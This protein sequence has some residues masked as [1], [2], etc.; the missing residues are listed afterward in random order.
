MPKNN[1]MH[2]EISTENI[3]DPRKTYVADL[4]L[5]TSAFEIEDAIERSRGYLAKVAMMPLSISEC[6]DVPLLCDLRLD[7]PTLYELN[8][9]AKQIAEFDDC[10]FAAYKAFL[11]LVVGDDYEDKIISIK[12]L[13]NLTY[14]VDDYMVAS[15]IFN[16]KDLGE[17]LLDNGLVNGIEDLP[18]E[19][20]D[21]LDP[22][23]VGEA[24]R[25]AENGIYADGFYISREGFKLKEIYD[26]ETLPD[27]VAD[28]YLFRLCISN[29]SL[30]N[31]WIDVPFTA[32]TEKLLDSAQGTAFF[33]NDFK[34]TIPQIV[35][36]FDDLKRNTIKIE[37]LK[38]INK[39]AERFLSA[40]MMQQIKFKA[41]LCYEGI[42]TLQ[43]MQ[44]IEA[45]LNTADSYNL[46][47][48]NIYPSD[49]AYDY[50]KKFLNPNF[51]EEY[52]PLI[53]TIRLG[54]RLA[55]EYDGKYTPYGI[56]LKNNFDLNQE[57]TNTHEFELIEICGRHV[58]FTEDR[59]SAD[60]IPENLFRYEFRSGDEYTYAT[61]EEKVRVDFSGT[62]LSKEPFD[63][64]NDGYI[65]ITTLGD[66]Y[67]DFLDVSMSVDDFIHSD[68]DEDEGEEI[69]G[70][71][72][73]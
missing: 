28:N 23:K 17:L 1:V 51:P 45:V 71:M 26:G 56:L 16:D 18:D 6:K 66:G 54:E 38:R 50:L 19:I 40:D 10:Q 9:L 39:F 59:L 11:P 29:A 24:H 52:L 47:P 4:H 73:L 36:C 21:M 13:I 69:V 27:N 42:L 65:D 48:L 60:E 30:N 72:Q 49:F 55:S 5:P 22:D 58:L 43:G 57:A 14:C 67:P 44:R 41:A 35:N 53:G 31:R 8:Y 37:E 33:L 32:D 25:I 34:S 64:G 3:D 7:S 61:L 63:L 12:D 70:G 46:K 2:I 62:I 20:V 15:N 68:Y